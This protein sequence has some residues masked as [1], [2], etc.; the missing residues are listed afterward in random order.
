MV[1]P[2]I[3][4]DQTGGYELYLYNIGG[5]TRA[6][7][8]FAFSNDYS[9]VEPDAVEQPTFSVFFQN[10]EGCVFTVPGARAGYPN[11]PAGRFVSSTPRAIIIADCSF[12]SQVSADDRG[13][14]MHTTPL[15][16]ETNKGYASPFNDYVMMSGVPVAVM[17]TGIRYISDLFVRDMGSLNEGLQFVLQGD[18]IVER[19]Y[20]FVDQDISG[21]GLYGFSCQYQSPLSPNNQTPV[22]YDVGGLYFDIPLYNSLPV[23]VA[24]SF[25][26]SPPTVVAAFTMTFVPASSDALPF[27]VQ[28]GFAADSAWVR[29]YDPAA[30][31]PV[32]LTKPVFARQRIES[33][34]YD[35]LVLDS[36]VFDATAYPLTVSS[37]SSFT[38]DTEGQQLTCTVTGAVSQDNTATATPTT[39]STAYSYVVDAMPL[40]LHNELFYVVCIS[41]EYPNPN[42][43][44]GPTATMETATYT[45]VRDDNPTGIDI[46]PAPLMPEVTLVPHYVQHT[47]TTHTVAISIMFRTNLKTA[48]DVATNGFS[49]MKLVYQG[50]Y[51][52]D[53]VV[54]LHHTDG[55][56]EPLTVEV[57]GP[58]LDDAGSHTLACAGA[59]FAP[60]EELENVFAFTFVIKFT[61]TG[62]VYPTNA[63]SFALQMQYSD[64]AMD[65]FVAAESFY[66]PIGKS[67]DQGVT[68]EPPMTT[69]MLHPV[70]GPYVATSSDYVQNKLTLTLPMFHHT[71]GDLTFIITLP[72]VYK[73]TFMVNSEP[74]AI[75]DFEVSCDVSFDTRWNAVDDSNSMP[76]N[77]MFSSPDGNIVSGNFEVPGSTMFNQ[78][79]TD[80]WST[81]TI[82]CTLPP[83]KRAPT[84]DTFVVLESFQ[85]NFQSRSFARLPPMKYRVPIV[86][87]PLLFSY[88]LGLVGMTVELSDSY[89]DDLPTS[90]ASALITA[91]LNGPYDFYLTNMVKQTAAVFSSSTTFDFD[92]TFRRGSVVRPWISFVVGGVTLILPLNDFTMP[93]YMPCSGSLPSLINA[94][95][96]ASELMVV[97]RNHGEVSNVA[98]LDGGLSVGQVVC[99]NGDWYK[100]GDSV[101]G[102]TTPAFSLSECQ[103]AAYLCD[104]RDGYPSG[105]NLAANSAIPKNTKFANILEHGVTYSGLSCADGSVPFNP[106]ESGTGDVSVYCTTKGKII[107]G[108]ATD[109][110]PA[111]TATT[112]TIPFTYPPNASDAPWPVDAL[113]VQECPVGSYP[114]DNTGTLVC[115]S[116]TGTITGNELQCTKCSRSDLALDLFTVVWNNVSH[117]TARYIEVGA[118]GVATCVSNSM[119]TADPNGD[120]T[121]T[122]GADGWENIPNCVVN[123]CAAFPV[124]VDALYTYNPNASFA[125]FHA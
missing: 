58:W 4:F 93:A 69:A 125:G 8:F 114:V 94:D 100:A 51:A 79:H 107:G 52:P 47:D 124:A 102:S 101:P 98:C 63:S 118:T 95:A 55:S 91:T 81:F 80:S 78:I 16:I 71:S 39:T 56:T 83:L 46:T 25:A 22:T 59:L 42:E 119:V 103:D 72:D 28:T 40:D 96:A 30:A 62:Y 86:T 2:I 50:L 65:A 66:Y 112:D 122:C 61:G 9:P 70:A 29:A 44:D 21:G 99:L 6:R 104:L 11:A 105:L 87:A 111:F 68:V 15:Y 41:A 34:D 36:K 97:S 109:S 123:G 115:D 88:P 60:F 7:Y 53:S 27:S 5:L 43:I 13:T 106:N 37:P 108:C 117:E 24:C 120:Q 113:G 12:T 54:F 18:G 85:D 26:T 20:A 33:L 64:G 48:F 75:I 35:V 76:F 31:D 57:P 92:M 49:G 116:D 38:Q 23:V 19:V 84:L 110:C 45:L 32:L 14:V 73:D 77:P 67:E 90:F 3:A 121:L 89:S 17:P 1:N 74:E 82:Q 10:T